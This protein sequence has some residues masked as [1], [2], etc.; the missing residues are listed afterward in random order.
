MSTIISYKQ[1]Q[2]LKGD[3]KYVLDDLNSM[4]FKCVLF[5]INF[6]ANNNISGV[7]NKFYVKDLDRLKNISKTYVGNL[8]KIKIKNLKKKL[9]N[10]DICLKF[11]FPLLNVENFKFKFKNEQ[12]FLTIYKDSD[13]LVEVGYSYNFK[14]KLIIS[15]NISKK[16]LNELILESRK[17]YE[18][19]ICEEKY[20]TQIKVKLFIEG[21]WNFL[22]NLN[23]REFSTIYLEDKI[24]NPFIQFIDKWSSIENEKWHSEMGIRYKLN[25]LLHGYPGTGKTSLIHALASHLNYDIYMLNFNN[26]L[27][28]S[29]FMNC[30]NSIK[31]NSSILVL[32]DI[33]CLFHERKKNDSNKHSITFSG[34]LNTLDGLST[35]HGLITVLTTNYKTKL[36]KALI[37]PGRIDYSVEFGYAKENQTKKMYN[38]FFQNNKFKSFWEK[39]KKNKFTTSLLQQYFIKCHH[40]KEDVL[41]HISDFSKSSSKINYDETFKNFYS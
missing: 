25:I 30:V 33:D 22:H 24:I 28:D 41:K 36:D 14:Y 32:E 18:E 35:K 12:F 27:D 2:K 6:L 38:K 4:P 31:S 5:Y 40:N 17:Y 3:Y 20:E 1:I 7:D 9:N 16:I 15:T 8:K 11:H 37:R 19:F 21:F 13:E 39:I 10:S 26:K 23:K 34:L 29:S